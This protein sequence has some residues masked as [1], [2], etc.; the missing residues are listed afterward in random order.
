MKR[1]AAI[2]LSLA[3][4]LSMAA[5]C[6]T[7]SFHRFEDAMENAAEEDIDAFFASLEETCGLVLGQK[8]SIIDTDGWSTGMLGSGYQA[9]G[10]VIAGYEADIYL[11]VNSGYIT[12]VDFDLRG[13]T[14]EDFETIAAAAEAVLGEADRSGE[15][16]VTLLWSGASLIYQSGASSCELLIY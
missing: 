7:G 8:E 12:G 3:L 16:I 15:S 10:F 6:A 4:L 2:L 9:S 1:C 13:I 14:Q 5:G 11:S